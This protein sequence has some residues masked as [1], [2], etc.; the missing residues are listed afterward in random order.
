M[1]LRLSFR[2]VVAMSYVLFFFF[3]AEDGIRDLVRSRGLGD[4]YKR[5]NDNP[6]ISPHAQ[7]KNIPQSLLD[8][9]IFLMFIA[10]SRACLLYTSD[11]ADERSSV[12]LGGRRIIKKKNNCIISDSMSNITQPVND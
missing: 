12:D 7:G 8:I 6:A 11:A 4:V 5:Q 1:Y 3:Q 2:F 9:R 10:L